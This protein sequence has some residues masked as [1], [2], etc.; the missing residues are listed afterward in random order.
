MGSHSDGMRYYPIVCWSAI[1]VLSFI[2]CGF[3][4][5]M[6]SCNLHLSVRRMPMGRV[7]GGERER[8]REREL[9]LYLRMISEGYERP[10]TLY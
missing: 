10:G 8:A 3:L 6:D 9:L 2:Q 5:L 4:Y 1:P 7:C